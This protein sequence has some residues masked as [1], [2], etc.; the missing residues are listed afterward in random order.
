MMIINDSL[1]KELRTYI[2]AKGK[3]QQTRVINGKILHIKP[4]SLEIVRCIEKY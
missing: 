2:G 4:K 3:K 1:V